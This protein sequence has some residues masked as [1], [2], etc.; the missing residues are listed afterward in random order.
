MVMDNIMKIL[1]TWRHAPIPKEL[2][3]ATIVRD[4]DETQGNDEKVSER[5]SD[6]TILNKKDKCKEECIGQWKEHCLDFK[7]FSK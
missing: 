3:I 2:M 7:F 4:R 6:L 1:S 5:S